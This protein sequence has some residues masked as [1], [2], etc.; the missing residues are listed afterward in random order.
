MQAAAGTS[1]RRTGATAILAALL[2][3]LA[4][5][6]PSTAQAATAP[7]HTTVYVVKIVAA[8]AAYQHAP[9]FRLDQPQPLTAAGRARHVAVFG[10]AT[11]TSST[12]SSLATVDSPRMRGP[13][14]DSCY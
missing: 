12:I 5:L 13:P 14:A 1:V 4:L 10:A 6:A 11:A 9:A 8:A 7:A 3:T 2:C